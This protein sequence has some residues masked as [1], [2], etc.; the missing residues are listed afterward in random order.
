MAAN[1]LNTLYEKLLHIGL[2]NIRQAIQSQYYEWAF[3]EVEMLHNVPSLLSE[4]NVERHRYFWFTER[5]AYIQSVN[6]NGPE[7]AQRRM[8]MCYAPVWME[9]EPFVLDFVSTNREP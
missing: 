2:I 1:D 4:S 9:M 8:N 5:K 3:A 7:I 6:S